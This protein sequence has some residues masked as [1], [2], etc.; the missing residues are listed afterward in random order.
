MKKV[1]F[2]NPSRA[3]SIYKDTKI[4]VA[5]PIM[6]PLGI[7]ALAA[8]SRRAGHDVRMLDLGVEKDSVQALKNELST[9]RPD[10]VGFTATTPLYKE[11]RKLSFISREMLGNDVTLLAG[12]PHVTAVPE[13]SLKE[14]EFDAIALGEGEDTLIAILSGQRFEEITGLGYKDSSG[15]VIINGSGRIINNLDDIP[16]PALDLLDINNYKSSSVITRK[17][18]AGPL[19][20]SRGCPYQCTFCNKNISGSKW[21]QKSPE[22]VIEEIMYLKKIGFREFHIIDDLFTVNLDKCKVIC[23]EM[24]RHEINMPWNL[25]VGV[26]VDRIDEEF[27]SLAAR[28]GCYQMGMGFESGDEESLKAIK[29]GIKLDQSIKAVKLLRKYKVESAG[30]FMLGLPGET[31][32][33]MKKTIDFAC[34]MSPDYA[35]AT[36]LVPLPGT[37]LFDDFKKQGLIKTYD[38]DLYDFHNGR[39]IYDHPNLPWDVLEKYY[40]MFHRKFYFRMSYI[41]KRIYKG[42]LNGKAFLDIYYAFK[43]F[44]PEISRNKKDRKKSQRYNGKPLSPFPIPEHV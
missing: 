17:N 12:G 20:T 21:R 10:Y 3:Y 2:V 15:K 39:N 30:F 14:S 28:A 24:I 40:E 43:I 13:D 37:V 41:L 8:V 29:K 16:L 34:K 9:F 44:S 32:E 6:P 18:P 26:R 42:L 27:V 36:I 35:K 33:K 38:W 4:G 1:L 7:S 19:E 31:E 11:I 25:R 22:R 23:E 5:I